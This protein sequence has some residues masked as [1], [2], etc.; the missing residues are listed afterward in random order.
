MADPATVAGHVTLLQG[1]MPGPATELLTERMVRLAGA[2]G[3]DLG[4][5]A[6]AGILVSVWSA[7]GGVKAIF[8]GVNTADDE[9]EKRSFLWLS[10]VTPAFAPGAMVLLVV[11]IGAGGDA[12]MEHQTERDRTTGPEKPMGARGGGNGRYA[13]RGGRQIGLPPCAARG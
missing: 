6:V 9:E 5:A 12:E 11:L 13:G 4:V 1:V 7:T 3:G 10:L 8:E 2:Q